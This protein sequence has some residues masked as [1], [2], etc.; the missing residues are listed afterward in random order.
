[1]AFA[2]ESVLHAG[3]G[4]HLRLRAMGLSMLGRILGGDEGEAIK[5]RAL[6]IVTS[7]DD[8]GLRLRFRYGMRAESTRTS[9]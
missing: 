2:R 3:D 8:E 7:L 1:V 6:A 5:A 4:G 9:S